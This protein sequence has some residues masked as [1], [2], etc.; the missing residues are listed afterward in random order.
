MTFSIT[1]QLLGGEHRE[2]T[3]FRSPVK[4]FCKTSSVEGERTKG[5]ESICKE[6]MM[7][8]HRI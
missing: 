8:D 5:V 2:G 3:V 6:I 1:S 4:E 7:M